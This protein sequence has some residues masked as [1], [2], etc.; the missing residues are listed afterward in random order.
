MA[1]SLASQ[2][3]QSGEPIVDRGTQARRVRPGSLSSAPA[4]PRGGGASSCTPPLAHCTMVHLLPV[5]HAPA[6]RGR[7]VA[8]TRAFALVIPRR[9]IARAWPPM[10]ARRFTPTRPATQVAVPIPRRTNEDPD[11][12]AGSRG[13]VTGKRELLPTADAFF[14]ERGQ[15][16]ADV[17]GDGTDLLLLS[18]TTAPLGWHLTE[19]TGTPSLDVYLQPTAPTGD[20]PPVVTGSRSLGRLAN[21]ATGRFALRMVDHVNEQAGEL[22]PPA[23]LQHGPDASSSGWRSGLEVVGNWW[24][25]H[26]AA[27]RLPT[28]LRTSCAPDPGPPSS[29]SG[30]WRP[31]TGSG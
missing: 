26:E 27:A 20:F 23:R 24:P 2:S 18:T 21:R 13:D 8:D 29:A 10:R 11:R 6:H 19:A 15:G 16:L 25:H 7:L 28:D 3:Q 31:V 5:R 12:P 1:G 14:T 9:S 30:A 22:A 4:S 17:I